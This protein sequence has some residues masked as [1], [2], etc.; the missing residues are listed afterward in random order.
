MRWRRPWAV[1]SN[2]AAH[3]EPWRFRRHS[4]E[5]VK[6]YLWVEMCLKWGPGNGFNCGS[7][8][9]S[10]RTRDDVAHEWQKARMLSV[11]SSRNPV[12]ETVV[13]VFSPEYRSTHCEKKIGTAFFFFFN[14]L[15]KGE[16]KGQMPNCANGLLSNMSFIQPPAQLVYIS[17]ELRH[18]MWEE[19]WVGEGKKKT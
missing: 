19:T 8:F 7:F 4:D 2:R 14:E 5:G 17:D 1:C 11:S 10:S 9:C 12:L 13:E 16:I 18:R 15:R 6:Y 3:G